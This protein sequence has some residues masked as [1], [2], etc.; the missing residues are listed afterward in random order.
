[1]KK[2]QLPIL[3][4]AMLFI[5]VGA[6]PQEATN[7]DS[8]VTLI[9]RW[10]NGPC[11][12]VFVVGN[13]AYIGNGGAI[14]ILDISYPA[15]PERV[16]QMITPSVVWGIHVSGNYVYVA[17]GEDGLYILRNDLLLGVASGEVFPLG[18]ALS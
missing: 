11:D 15:T 6:Y 1:M 7:A 18:F 17:D 12:A 14:D 16:G 13:Y 5:S 3:T 8:N 4:F 2:P 10:P 9:G